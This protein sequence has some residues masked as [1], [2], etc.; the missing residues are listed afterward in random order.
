MNDASPNRELLL[1]NTNSWNRDCAASCYWVCM[2][3]RRPLDVCKSL[4][5]DRIGAGTGKA[6]TER[7]VLGEDWDG[8]GRGV[9]GKPPTSSIFIFVDHCEV[10]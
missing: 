7:G 8:A 3:R 1:D 2:W 10:Y 4:D 5:G 9:H 6:G